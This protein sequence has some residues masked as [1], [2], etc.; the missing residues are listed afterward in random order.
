[1]ADK[2]VEAPEATDVT[3]GAESLFDLLGE[4][5]DFKEDEDADDGGEADEGDPDEGDP[6][7]DSDDGDDGDEGDDSE[8]GDDDDD[9][10]DDD[11]DDDSDEGDD[12]DD[13]DDSE[14]AEDNDADQTYT[15]KVD[16]KEV[17]VTLDE[18]LAGWMRQSAFTKKTM[19]VAAERKQLAA[20]AVGLRSER[21]E[22][23]NQLQVL[24]ET[25]QAL[26][27]AE[28]DWDALR[29]EDP[30]KF[31]DTF[32][33]YQLRQKQIKAVQDERERVKGEQSEALKVAQDVDTAD[34]REKLMLAFPE[35]KDADKKSVAQ[36]ALA[37]Y[38]QSEYGFT[39][40]DL[41]QVKDHRALIMLHKSM[42]WDNAQKKGSKA[43]KKAK[44]VPTLKPGSS[45]KGKKSSKTKG[46]DARKRLRKSGSV[47]DAAAALFE[48]FP[49]DD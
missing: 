6:D 13:D 27:P 25:I 5:P 44:K 36:A 19:A 32:A 7:D 8:D 29:K 28:P 20:D 11:D 24:E 33:A 17:E 49:E 12:E 18:A 16:G 43:R 2:K 3:G 35:W 40:D 23:A 22:Y 26:T 4:D 1:M 14:G 15:V 37:Q 10:E 9:D 45:S 34:E 47:D 31:A 30:A 41:A 48:M 39:E 42:L 46:A 38:A 21:Q